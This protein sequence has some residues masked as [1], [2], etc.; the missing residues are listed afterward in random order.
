MKRF[1]EEYGYV[2]LTALVICLY[3]TLVK[4]VGNVIN[5]GLHDLKNNIVN[6]INLGDVSIDSDSAHGQIYKINYNLNGGTLPEGA[7]TSYDSN[8]G[9]G[10][11][12]IPIRVG[13]YSFSGWKISYDNIKDVLNNL[14]WGNGNSECR[15]NIPEDVEFDYVAYL[16]KPNDPIVMF[17]EDLNK[18]YN[19]WDRS[20]K[21]KLEKGNYTITLSNSASLTVNKIISINNVISI[22]RGTIGDVNLL[23]E[24]IL[25]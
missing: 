13:G 4:P 11:L 20:E 7:M 25:I 23:A 6:T 19:L 14:D 22:P 16:R 5:L 21:I 10:L 2:I 3:I 12:P 8:K 18:T 24:W 15:F 1:F 17:N 9:L